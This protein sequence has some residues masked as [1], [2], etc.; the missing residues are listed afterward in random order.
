[1]LQRATPSPTTPV[2]TARAVQ[3]DDD[4]RTAQARK[5]DEAREAQSREAA[6][7]D[8]RSNAGRTTGRYLDITV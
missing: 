2:P 7:S 5:D 6:K 3:R 8:T 4:D 1:M